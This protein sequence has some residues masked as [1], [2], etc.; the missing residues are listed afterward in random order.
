MVFKSLIHNLLVLCIFLA[1]AVLK[2]TMLETFLLKTEELMASHVYKGRVNYQALSENSKLLDEVYALAGQIKIDKSEADNYKAFW[3][4]AYNITVI[5]TITDHYPIKS[6]MDI[7]GF[8]DS[9]KHL[10]G[11]REISLNYLEN[12]LLRS[13]FDEPRF[14]F[15]LVC[16]AISCPVIVNFAYKP[17]KLNEQMEAQSLKAINDDYFIRLDSTR[18]RVEVSQI[19][20][21]YLEDFAEDEKGLIEYLN[22]YRK[23]KIAADSKIAYYHYDWS[24]NE[25]KSIAPKKQ[26]VLQKTETNQ[27][28]RSIWKTVEPI[29]TR[30]IPR[31]NLQTF[32]PGTLLR[33]GQSDFSIFNTLYTETKGNWQGNDLNGFRE[34]FMT[35]QLQWTYGVSENKRLNIGLDV[36]LRG[37]G[38]DDRSDAVSSINRAF[39]FDKSDSSRYGISLIGAR[40]KVS[41][42]KGVNNFAIQS[43]FLVSPANNAE[44]QAPNPDVDQWLEWDRFIWWNQFFYDK[45]FGASNQF[46]IFAEADLLFRFKRRDYQTSHLDLPSN[47]FFSY[48][49][50][51]KTT[52]YIMSQ[53]VPRFVFDTQQKVIVSGAEVPL[54]NDWVIGADY[55]A[56]GLGFK[57]QFSSQLNV[58]VLYT[59]FW[60]AR[61]GGLGQTFNLGIKYLS[62]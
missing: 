30:Q 37:A 61:N 54:T 60:K 29:D 39:M 8:F 50:T 48:F 49:P 12:E 35:S 14:H 21:W 56:S 44:G 1:P 33:K 24:L 7:P 4:N 9:K 31:S 20:K 15:V 57:Y 43:T 42:I 45:T 58:E 51:S 40:I 2:A 22:R 59:N 16:G 18:K 55:A 34:T 38:R 6:P 5:K 28:K 62:K 36:Y 26:V 10:L 25:A 52:V 17:E 41:P 32:T 46:Q 11:G 27:K 47:L 13:H 3:I 19:F 23:N 53:Y